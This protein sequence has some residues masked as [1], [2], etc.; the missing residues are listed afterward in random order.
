MGHRVQKNS[1]G[2]REKVPGDQE[3]ERGT[4]CPLGRG[5]VYS[6]QVEILRVFSG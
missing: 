2:N 5:V 6:L 4:A 3:G 1:L